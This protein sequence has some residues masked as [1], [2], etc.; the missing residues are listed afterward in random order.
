[1]YSFLGLITLGNPPSVIVSGLS[2]AGEVRQP[3]DWET[4]CRQ[5]EDLGYVKA[6]GRGSITPFL[7]SPSLRAPWWPCLSYIIPPVRNLTHHWLTSHA[8]GA[9][10]GEVKG[11]RGGAPAREISLV[12]LVAYGSKVSE[13]ALP[14]GGYSFWNQTG[15][16]PTTSLL[17]CIIIQ[18]LLHIKGNHEQNENPQ[19]DIISHPLEWLL[20]KRQ[21]INVSEDVVKNQSFCNVCR[22]V[23]GCSH[24]GKQYGGSSENVK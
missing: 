18:V 3:R 1:M 14:M 2:Q 15:R 21:E 23:N 9:K 5:N 24:C 13:S 12:S 22:N 4:S 16:F 11:G 20:S 8:L 19:W 6:E 7:H 10:Q 17:R